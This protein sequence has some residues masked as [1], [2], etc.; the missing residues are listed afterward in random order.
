MGFTAWL[1]L[2]YAAL[3][4]LAALAFARNRKAVARAFVG[5]MVAG[6]VVLGYL[7]FTSPM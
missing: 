4:A 5:V 7:L 1:M 2:A 6:V 3:A